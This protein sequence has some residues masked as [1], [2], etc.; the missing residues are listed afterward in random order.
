LRCKSRQSTKPSVSTVVSLAV[1][2]LEFSGDTDDYYNAQNSS[3]MHVLEARSG[4][5]ITL[6]IAMK[7]ILHRLGYLVNVAGL[8]GHAVLA[9]SD[10]QRTL[11][12]DMFNGQ[13][14]STA[15]CR[16]IAEEY[17][18]EWSAQFLSPLGATGILRRMLLRNVAACRVEAYTSS[19]T[20]ENWDSVDKIHHVLETFQSASILF[21]Q[22][23]DGQHELP[24]V[25]RPREQYS[26]GAHS[27]TLAL[28]SSSASGEEVLSFGDSPSETIT[29][30]WS[31][32]SD[33][34]RIVDES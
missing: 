29:V 25:P 17:F 7:L 1:D 26:T 31:I 13:V 27:N 30:T 2:V 34:E 9:I 10:G 14:L 21:E 28:S 11:Y 8:P 23:I 22:E 5:P 19:P 6:A 3:I 20:T 16:D 33:C 4:I 32:D 15:D 24:G 18:D 12:M